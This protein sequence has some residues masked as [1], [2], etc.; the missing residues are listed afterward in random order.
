M[1]GSNCLGV[2]PGGYFMVA[3]RATFKQLSRGQ[4]PGETALKSLKVLLNIS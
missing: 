3:L 4:D 2:L 1:Q